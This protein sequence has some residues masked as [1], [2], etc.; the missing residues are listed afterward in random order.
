MVGRIA[1]LISIAILATA[2]CG[3]GTTAP[4]RF[5]TLD[6]TATPDGAPPAH[7]AVMVGP[8]TIPASVDQPEFVSRL[9]RTASK[10]TNSTAGRRR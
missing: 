2:A 6:S 5:Y 8:V 10:L 7:M 1:R 4:A 3:C 9:R